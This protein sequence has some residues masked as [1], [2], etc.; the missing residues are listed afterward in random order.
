[1]QTFWEEK[2]KVRAYDVD[3]KNK[4]KVSSVFNYMQD[5]AST[6]ADNVSAGYKQLMQKNLFWVLSWVKL[7]FKSLPEFEDNFRIKTWPKGKYKFYALRDFLLFD[8][9]G[10]VFC[11]I[12]SAWLL[13]NIK[14]KRITDLK[15]LPAEIP[16]N[17]NESALSDLPE[18]ISVEN[19]NEIVLNKKITYSDIDIN[20]HVNNAKYIEFISDGYSKEFHEKYFMKSITV[21]FK[22]ETRFGD[23]IEIGLNNNPAMKGIHY[24]EGINK[25]TGKQAFQALINWQ[26]EL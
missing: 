4:L 21:S 15:N 6:H 20:L 13:L 23:I 18:K 9:N 22:S 2:L 19:T 1:M 26:D 10:E 5:A 3:F 12:A 11:K 14:N 17:P 7:Q 16:V 24:L 8:K 25:A